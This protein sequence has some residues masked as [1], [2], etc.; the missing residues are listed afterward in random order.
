[1]IEQATNLSE[2]SLIDLT[3]L[4]IPGEGWCVEDDEPESEAKSFQIS[5]ADREKDLILEALAR[6][7]GNKSKA[8]RLL[9]IHRSVLYK[10][11]A[12]LKI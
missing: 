7:D 1:M 12:R 6:A 5:V 3:R 9:N 10:K 4:L 8:A 2:E 11:I